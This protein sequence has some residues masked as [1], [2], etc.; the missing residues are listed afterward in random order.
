MHFAQIKAGTPTSVID[1]FGKGVGQTTRT[2]IV[3]GE[4]GC[5]RTQ[6][7]AM[8]DDLLGAALNFGVT[9]L[10]GVKV[11]SHAVAATGQGAGS[12]SSHA[13]AHAWT[14]QLNQQSAWGEFDFAGEFA[15][16]HAQAPR[17][18]DGLVV[19][20]LHTVNHLLVLAEITEQIGAAKLVVKGRTAQRTLGHDGQGVGHV[21]GLSQ[22][23]APQ[24]GNAKAS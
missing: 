2:H 7:I 24:F 6:G 1:Q 8:V 17:N 9:A 4:D 14:T 13:N 21:G 15:L 23:A 5:H 16:H 10:Y 18:H 22:T 11:Q 19:A 3:D 12:A 20:A